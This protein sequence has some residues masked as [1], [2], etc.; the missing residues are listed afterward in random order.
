MYL[1][2]IEIYGFKTFVNNT[3]IILSKGIN[4][5]VGPNGS[6]KSNIVDAIRFLFGENK[7]SLLRV[8]ETSDLVF[9]GSSTR[10]AMNTASVKVIIN[11]EDRQL[12][13][14]TPR[15]IIER[16][17]I[18][19]SDSR[20]FL[21][22][23]G[24]SLQ[25]V[26]E[27]FRSANI[28][29]LNQA[30]VG[31][32]RIEEL[33][34]ARPEEKKALIDRVAG[35][36]DLRK[37]KEEAT[38][39]L[40]ETEENLS[41]VGSLLSTVKQEYERILSESQKVHIYYALT[42]D[43]KKLEEKLFSLRI[44]KVRDSIKLYESGIE[45]KSK[46]ENEIVTKSLGVKETFE[47]THKQYTELNNALTVL[48]K[49]REEHILK[50]A[51][52]ETEIES[53]RNMI[54]L[55]QN[56]FEEGI[57]RIEKLNKTK[58]YIKGDIEKLSMELK[59]LSDKLTSL[60]EKKSS[61]GELISQKQKELAPIEMAYEGFKRE[62]EEK[63]SKRIVLEKKISVLEKEAEF[64][65]KKIEELKAQGDILS[66]LEVK[67]VDEIVSKLNFLTEKIADD[68]EKLKKLESDLAV[69]NFR[70]RELKM[71]LDA[72][73]L[74]SFKE[75]SLGKILKIDKNLFGLKEYLEGVVIKDIKEIYES[76]ERR[77]FIEF[78]SIAPDEIP[79]IK[80]I[81]ALLN[82]SSPFFYGI[83]VADTLDI[84]IKSFRNYF[85]TRYIRQIITLDGFV[86]LSPYEVEKWKGLNVD[87]EKEYEKLLEQKSSLDMSITVLKKE[88][89]TDKTTA[90]NLSEELAK[91]KE[92]ERKVSERKTIEE[93]I[94]KYTEELN[95]YTEMLD[96]SKAELKVQF[97]NTGFFDDSELNTKKT[98]IASLKDEL[99][100]VLLMIKE[101]EMNSMNYKKDIEEKKRRMVS[102][103]NEVKEVEIK[104]S[105]LT[106]EIEDN[107]G[108]L[109]KDIS[110]LNEVELVLAGLDSSIKEKNKQL[111]DFKK[112]EDELSVQIE[113][114]ND[115]KSGIHESIER[116]RLNL[117]KEEANLENLLSA[118]KER[119]LREIDVNPN[120]SEDSLKND[121][122]KLKAEIEQLEPLDF[123]SIDKEDEAKTNYEEKKLVYDDVYAAKKEL[124]KYIGELEKTIKTK[125][126]NTFEALKVHFQNIFIDIFSQGEA[127]L[128]KIFDDSEEVA[129][130]EI[131]VRLPF[132]KKQPLSVLSGGEK[133]LVALAFL[134]AIFEIN[135]SPFYI[136]DEVDAALDDENVYK[137]GNLI[138]KFS[139]QSQ[140]LIITHNKQTM[141][142]A[143]ILYGITMEEDG[144]SKVVSLKLV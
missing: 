102:I 143:D 34:L 3:K 103:E 63:E 41:K 64:R 22:G 142:K 53:L 106:K 132:K 82:I 144:L 94:L 89:E 35:I 74:P 76:K 52:L 83:Y 36:Y 66:K 70:I 109:N 110:E 7:L 98:E 26:L 122:S 120:I 105:S 39:K 133:T 50:R 114:L 45:E 15:V 88:I 6:G 16:R 51:K 40:I 91:A 85:R 111:E 75:G 135:P 96:A 127:T 140:F 9:A 104:N 32:G 4:C 128:E 67:D 29:G 117:T 118:L 56:E 125:F 72:S 47:S 27:I 2:S 38:K 11:N 49:N 78:D 30:I 58:A 24:S 46:E 121:I 44:K 119:E 71:S 124:E 115:L 141:E 86:L 25:D 108:K 90:K 20:Y 101:A 93:E 137:F 107:E 65:S 99:S 31:Q 136:L 81:S 112:K 95:Q 138:E 14:K 113:Q 77:F 123:T 130:V 57:L 84:G 116:I 97:T 13:I 126:D 100:K 79:E 18:K 80:P 17:L 134:F 69:L 59:E 37:K 139:E 33:L 61:L 8:A 12:P 42:S 19:G 68:E 54:E 23:E 48:N 87:E 55:K 28:Y 21:N 60:N 5:I 131:S 62:F 10:E 1:E 92:V 43:L 129:G 73:K